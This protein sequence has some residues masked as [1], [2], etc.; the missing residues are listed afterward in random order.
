MLASVVIPSYNRPDLI[1]RTVCAVAVQTVPRGDYEVIVV[2]DHSEPPVSEAFH[3]RR[4]PPG[5]RIVRCEE[6]LGRAGARN[7]G[8]RAARG[9]VVVMLDD[10]MEVVRHFLESHLRIHESHGK[11]V[12]MGKIVA[13]TELGRDP[14]LSYL[15]SRGPEKVRPGQVLPSR[16]FVTGNSSVRRS[17]L[18]EVGLFDEEFQLYGG[19]DTD[20]G[21]RLGKA[22]CA[23]FYAP[24]ALARHLHVVS[25]DRLCE[26]LVAYG[27]HTLPRMVERHP[28]LREQMSLDILDPPGWGRLPLAQSVRRALF[29][30]SLRPS[31]RRAARAL[32]RARWLG[33]ALYPVYDYLRAYSYMTGYLEAKEKGGS[34]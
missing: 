32:T 31:V 15:D 23:F 27:R 25:L 22:G 5:V 21:V 33:R 26:R 14:F 1:V 29:Q 28:E 16:Y 9:E 8:I 34:A 7:A 12:G 11:A 3:G 4:L 10:D 24:E 18:E 20:L 13:A 19:E 2:D 17:V 30:I 6:N